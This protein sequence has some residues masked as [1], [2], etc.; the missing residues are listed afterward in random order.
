M[1]LVKYSPI[2]EEL[3]GSVNGWTFSH[4]RSGSATKSKSFP[5]S[6]NPFTPSIDQVQL[7]QYFQKSILE[8]KELDSAQV[9]SWV[10]LA[11]QVPRSSR[12][13]TNYYSA[14]YNLFIEVNQ[15]RQILSKSLLDDAPELPHVA[16]IAP[17]TISTI[18]ILNFTIKV[19]FTGQTTE[20]GITH[21]VFATPAISAGRNYVNNYYRL[22]AFIPESTADSYDFSSEYSAEFPVPA[23]NKKIAIKIYP[24]HDASGFAGIETT[25][26]TITFE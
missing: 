21:F 14:A 8:W 10:E 15:R 16:G 5:G 7:R 24:V 25:A 26:S 18:S 9:L 12:F 1:A 17:I 13:G 19:N 22:C 20:A 11:K 3:S 6:V 4:V 2:I 23:A